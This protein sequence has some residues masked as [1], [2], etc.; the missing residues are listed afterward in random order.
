MINFES[1][2]LYLWANLFLFPDQA[3]NFILAHLTSHLLNTSANILRRGSCSTYFLKDLAI[4][5]FDSFNQLFV[6]DEFG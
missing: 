5:L 1:E 3:F 2:I 6:V 4:L